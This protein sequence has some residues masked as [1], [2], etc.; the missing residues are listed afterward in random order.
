[1]KK[2]LLAIV[3]FA[4]F[5]LSLF[6]LAACKKDDDEG[7]LTVTWYDATGTSTVSDM[8]VLKTEKVDSGAKVQRYVPTKEGAYTFVDWFAVPSKAHRF[9]FDTAITEDTAIYAGFSKQQTDTRSFYVVGSGSSELLFSSNWGKVITDSHKLSKAA[10]KNEYSITLDLMQGDEFQLAI[11]SDWHNQRGFG[12]LAETKLSDGTE[13]F[14]SNASP[15]TDAAKTANIKVEKAGNYTLK[16]TTYPADDYY[17]TTAPNYT[18]ATKETYNRGTYDTISW[19]RNGD[20]LK[21]EVTVT[22]FYIK[23]EKITGWGDVYNP[24]TQ[25]VRNGDVYTLSV[26]LKKDDQFMFTSRLTKISNGQNTVSVGSEYI[27]SN[28]LDTASQSLVDGYSET[29]ANMKAKADGTYKFSYN[30]TS[31]V[32]TVT[33][34]SEPAPQYDFYLDGNIGTGDKWNAFVDS[35]SDYKLTSDGNGVYT[36]TKQLAAGKSIQIRACKAGE[37]ATT[38]NT[39][40]NLYQFDYLK[41]PGQDFEATSATDNNIKVK[42]AGNYDISIDSYSKLIT[43]VPHTESKDT[44][45]VYIKGANINGWNHNFESQ[46]KFKLSADG[47]SYE[48]T[49][50]VEADKPMEFGLEVFAKGVTSGYGTFVNITAKGNTGDANDKFVKA[51]AETN[52]NITCSV[53]GTYKVVYNIATEKVD[54]YSVNA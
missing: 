48:F 39:A 43:I 51:A 34:V 3:L 32:L 15:Y 44:L 25:M 6:A 50:T 45:D 54:F 29:G 38:S 21:N 13:V 19:V 20:V 7:K 17:E 1:M 47:E 31:K 36:I 42:K 30:S 52:N 53:A 9:D 14:S 35:P 23:G 26:W 8:P 24:S 40:G 37:T 22:D 10:D 33:Y 46:W 12:Y 27:K 28:N 49:L 4:V 16:L 5:A 18:E 11:D 2:K 41:N